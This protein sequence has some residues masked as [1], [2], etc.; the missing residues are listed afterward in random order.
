MW[1]ITKS[2]TVIVTEK[3]MD[4]QFLYKS[5]N[6]KLQRIDDLQLLKAKSQKTIRKGFTE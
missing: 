4:F 2:N 1:I 3:V 5:K 6:I